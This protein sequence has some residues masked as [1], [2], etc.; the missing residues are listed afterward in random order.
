VATYASTSDVA[1]RVGLGTAGFDEAE[2][3]QCQ[4]LLEDVSEIMRARLPSLDTWIL[5]GSVTEALAK[6]AACWMAMQCITVANVGVGTESEQH[7]EHAVTITDAASAGI[8]LPAYW[9]S[10]L[11]PATEK[12]SSAAFTITPAWEY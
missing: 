10:L 7:P 3:A 5:A 1:T 9:I 8:D 2:E 11:T 4:A 12:T 6:S